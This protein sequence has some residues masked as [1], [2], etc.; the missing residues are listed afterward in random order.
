MMAR[1]HSNHYGKVAVLY[2]G[3]SAEREISIKSGRAVLAAL[4]AA[5]VDAHGVDPTPETL[6]GLRAAGYDRVFNILHGTP[7]ED[8][9]LQAVCALQGLP[10]TGSGL[11]ASANALDKV[12]TKALWRQ[13]GIPVAGDV[14][15]RDGQTVDTDATVAR[16][17]LPVYVKPAWEGSS[18]GV[19]RVDAADDLA[20]AVA[21]AARHAGPVLIEAAVAGAEY[22][23]GVVGDTWLPL[24]RI[25]PARGFYDFDAKYVS[26]DTRYVIPC[27]LDADHETRLQQLS[28]HAFAALGCTGWGRV[29]FMLDSAGQPV[30]LEANT[31]PGM[32]DHSLVPKAAAALGW[33]MPTLCERILRSAGTVAQA[34]A[35]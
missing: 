9:V 29:D 35:A 27:G 8:G 3:W 11:Q 10:V 16:L 15:V 5:G 33:D 19:T 21:A 7:G 1:D 23:A 32:T 20:A 14:V 12:A 30:F 13:A 28:A 31:T 22:T 2:G 6:L 26:D 17:G 24:I 25:E 34:G 18:V 4:Q